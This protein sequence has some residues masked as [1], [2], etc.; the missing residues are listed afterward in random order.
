MGTPAQRLELAG[1]GPS[2]ADHIVHQLSTP[3]EPSERTRSSP[4]VVPQAQNSSSHG[5]DLDAR[6][7]RAVDEV[8]QQ[9]QRHDDIPSSKLRSRPWSAEKA[10]VPAWWVCT[11][12]GIAILTTV[13][14]INLVGDGLNE[15]LN[16]GLRER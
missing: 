10:S 2:A 8:D 4:C 12:P 13:L 15:A 16:P 1:S 5:S 14:A 6:V 7:E 9:V 11:F 3:T